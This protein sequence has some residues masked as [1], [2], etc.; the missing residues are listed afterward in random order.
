MD[1]WYAIVESGPHEGTVGPSSLILGGSWRSVGGSS[2][3][4][5]HIDDIGDEEERLL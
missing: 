4:H 3:G 1:I 5:P 2:L